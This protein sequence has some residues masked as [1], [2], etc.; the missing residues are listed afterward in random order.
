MTH[1]EPHKA[2]KPT[3]EQLLR[4]PDV[5]RGHSHSFVPQTVLD[6]GY[7]E[8]NQ[9]LQQQGWPSA[10]MVEVCQRYHASEWYLFHPAINQLMQASPHAHLAL[11]NPPAL[12]FISG[13]R[14]WSID[15]QRLFVVQSTN[16]QEFVTS[17]CELSQSPACPIVLAWQNHPALNYTQLRKLQLSTSEQA[18]LYVLFRH[19]RAQEQSSPANLRL[20]IQTQRNA[21]HIHIFKQKGKLRHCDIEL[22]I[23]EVWQAL[24]PHPE[25]MQNKSRE[26]NTRYTASSK[27]QVTLF[28]AITSRSL[29]QVVK[30]DYSS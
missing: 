21:L 17:F 23:P 15:T 27:G 28:P 18:G 13:L 9:A 29:K 25:L 1:H 4:R 7:P 6:S 16:A 22:P 3:L 12:P 2:H 11:L 20:S 30:R 8:L 24:P 26:S 14:Q 19:S 10:S 5:W